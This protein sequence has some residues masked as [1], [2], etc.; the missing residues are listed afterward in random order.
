MDAKT[1]VNHPC[2]CRQGSH[3]GP[4][5]CDRVT[6][7]ASATTDAPQAREPNR[8]SPRTFP[9]TT[10]HFLRNNYHLRLRVNTQQSNKSRGVPYVPHVDAHNNAWISDTSCFGPC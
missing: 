2:V 10:E 6:D 4:I 8:N 3:E 9:L 7:K 1:S 5:R